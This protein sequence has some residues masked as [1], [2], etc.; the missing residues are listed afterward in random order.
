[1]KPKTFAKMRKEGIKIIKYFKEKTRLPDTEL[2]DCLLVHWMDYIKENNKED[3]RQMI[4]KHRNCK[5]YHVI[6][7]KKATC[8]DVILKQLLEEK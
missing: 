6:D 5:A 8:L 7:G 3:I 2:H 1:M 4:I